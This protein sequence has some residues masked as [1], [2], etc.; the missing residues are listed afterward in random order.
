MYA[1]AYVRVHTY[2]HT[3][4]THCSP[5]GSGVSP[6]GPGGGIVMTSG[7]PGGG[8]GGVGG[9]RASWVEVGWGGGE[10]A[11]PAPPPSVGADID[12]ASDVAV[13]TSSAEVRGL[14]F[15]EFA[16][17]VGEGV[18]EALADDAVGGGGG[19]G[20]GGGAAAPAVLGSGSHWLDGIWNFCTALVCTQKT[21]AVWWGV[22][23]CVCACVLWV[24]V[25]TRV[26]VCAC[27]CMCACVYASTCAYDL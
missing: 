3:Q 8:M 2:R 11:P 25:C 24:S 1:Y 26:Y 14:A 20:G 23:V 15:A 7:G 16:E 9:R 6:G 4:H 5:L 10:G 12:V 17:V 13:V 22:C 19:G 18:A 27:V 21:Y